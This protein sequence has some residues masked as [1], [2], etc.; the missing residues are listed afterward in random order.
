MIK[1]TLKRTIDELGISMYKLS[2]EAKSRGGTVQTLVDESA[3]SIRFDKLNALLDAL[4]FIASEKGIN[5]TYTIS[6]II[7]YEYV[8]EGSREWGYSLFMYYLIIN[9]LY[10]N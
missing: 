8:R 10:S 3:K 1:F 4:N 7:D 5:K 2:T 9:S 6:D